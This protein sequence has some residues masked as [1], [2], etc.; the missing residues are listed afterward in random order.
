MKAVHFGAGNIGRGF[1]GLLLSQSGY[2]V[3]FVTRNEKKVSLL[4]QAGKYTVELADASSTSMTVDNITASNIL[5]QSAVTSAMMEADLVTTAV[6]VHSLKDI[7]EPIAK[8]IERRLQR[9]SRPLHVIACENT[10]GGSSQLKKWVYGHL[11]PQ[12][13]QLADKF[14]RFPNS[15]VDRIIPE[16]H[17][18]N[19]LKVRVEPYFEWVIDGSQTLEGFR[20]IEGATFVNQLTP[21]IER[22]LFTVNTGHC[23]AAYLGYL[24]GY[25]TIQQAME[26]HALRNQVRAVLLETGDLLI[27]QY[28][29]DRE[30]H[31]AY[32]ERILDRF[33]TPY[34]TDDVSRVARCPIRKLSPNDRLVRPLLGLHERG[35]ET[36][37]LVSVI[38]AALLFDN[39]SDPQV[40]TLQTTIHKHGVSRAITKF[41]GIS[42]HHALHAVIEHRYNE[43]RDARRDSS[44]HA[45]RTW[46]IKPRR[47]AISDSKL[48]AEV[49]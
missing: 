5:D 48:R 13:K 17:H 33:A 18:E 21:Y 2:E 20:E 1:I 41:L 37:A 47:R 29:F 8:G 11:N 25:D 34:L 24:R 26:D 31:K 38:V 3:N 39:G 46:L 32:I 12:T 6:G 10:I 19:P 14:V 16:Q 42:R 43:L 28:Q 36:S 4:R 35:M 22:K 44:D 9:Q 45:N 23:S 27:Q 49:R 30:E 40:H 7:A 15:A